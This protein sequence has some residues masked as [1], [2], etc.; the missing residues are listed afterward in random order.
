MKVQLFGAACAACEKMK[1]HVETAVLE[2]RIPCELE[3]V[4]RIS[5]MI[6]MGVT[7]TPTLIVNGEV[8]TAGRVLEV[9]AIKRTLVA[10]AAL[11]KQ[12]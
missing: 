9:E 1:K 5:D 4:T 8:V 2:L 11:E 3:H 12:P 7:Q 10:A 6:E